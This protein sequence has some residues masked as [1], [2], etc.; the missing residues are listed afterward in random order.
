MNLCPKIWRGFIGLKL[1]ECRVNL[2]EER[3]KKEKMQFLH[4]LVQT[5]DKDSQ[6]VLYVF[7]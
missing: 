2:T 7:W 6:L 5:V 3:R 4:P 1:R